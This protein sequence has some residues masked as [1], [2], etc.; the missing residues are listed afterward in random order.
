MTVL[1]DLPAVRPA[2]LADT[3]AAEDLTEHVREF[4][5][6]LRNARAEPLA[7]GVRLVVTL[8]LRAIAAFADLVRSEADTLPYFHFRVLADPP[9]CWLEVTGQG[10][11][12]DVARAL[13]G[14]MGA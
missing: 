14:E 9:E 13:F 10:R 1:V 3:L 6:Y 12:G 8:D 5:R 11:A 7:E 4:R 2:R